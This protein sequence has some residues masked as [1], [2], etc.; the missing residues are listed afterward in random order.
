M[1]RVLLINPPSPERL[2][3]PLLGLQYVAAALLAHGCEVRVI[4][5][6]ACSCP[7]DPGT[8][9]AEAEDF[10]PQMVGFSLYTRWVRHAYGLAGRLRGRFPM[11]VAGG[12]HATACPGEVLRAGFDVAVL[13]EAEYAVT[14]LA[15]YLDGTVRLEE[16][17]GIRFADAAGNVCGDAPANSVSALD[18]LPFPLRARHLFQSGWYGHSRWPAISDGIVASRG[19]PARCTFC[20]NTATGRN[21][22]SRS[23]ANVV[24]EMSEAWSTSGATFFPFWDDVLTADPARVMGLCAAIEEKLPF[25]PQWSAATR[26]T[27]VQPA[28]LAAMKR[29]GLL[30]LTFGV[31]S[32]DDGTLEAIGKAIRT[33]DVVRALEM[34]RTA[35]LRTTCNFMFGFP[36]ETPEALDHTLHFMERISPMVDF[37]SPSGVLIPMPGTLVYEQNH[38]RYGFTEWWLKEEYSRSEARRKP[39]DFGQLCRTAGCDPVLE[40]DFF[41]YTDEVRARI[42]ACLDFKAA[43][44]LQRMRPPQTDARIPEIPK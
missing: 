27:M 6:A 1:T 34:A 41:R 9:V 5:A 2:G 18:S 35:G 31:E 24:A 33:D 42:R 21:F 43:H 10:A 4:D 44:N 40:L 23:P 17:P 7:A 29:A 14:A 16:I 39:V 15:D 26:V 3:G 32:G 22:R 8:I 37:F 11:L 30:H 20:A 28:L 12:P 25:T 38:V 19:C 36:E 13:G